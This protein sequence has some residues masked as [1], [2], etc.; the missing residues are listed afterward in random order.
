MRRGVVGR[1]VSVAASG[2]GNS[3]VLLDAP[4]FESVI[5]RILTVQV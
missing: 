2:E 1:R 4:A 5:M 3:G